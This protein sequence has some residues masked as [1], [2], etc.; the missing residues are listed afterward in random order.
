MISSADPPIR[1]SL[2]LKFTNKSC[3]TTS[4]STTNTLPQSTRNNI[5]TLLGCRT[6]A[7]QVSKK[8]RVVVLSLLLASFT[9]VALAAKAKKKSAAEMEEQ[10]DDEGVPERYRDDP[11]YK[12]RSLITQTSSHLHVNV[13]VCERRRFE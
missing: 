10:D 1:R 6:R 9:D 3:T 11:R 2:F 5:Q 7:R 4:F 12:V 8:M 13:L